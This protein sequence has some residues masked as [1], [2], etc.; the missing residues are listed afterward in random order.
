[1]AML[2]LFSFFSSFWYLLETL[3]DIGREYC[4][5]KDSTII[6]EKYHPLQSQITKQKN[7][8]D[9]DRRRHN[10][11]DVVGF[12]FKPVTVPNNS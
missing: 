2:N 9:K 11:Y 3:Y 10:I 4:V 5:S 6:L 12:G 7:D 8:R 1:M